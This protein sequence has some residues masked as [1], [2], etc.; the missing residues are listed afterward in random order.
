MKIYCADWLLPISSEPIQ[1]AAIAIEND[2]II[3][4]GKLDD[5]V[6]R[7]MNVPIEDFGEAVLMPGFVNTHSH[8]ELTALR[9]FLDNVE[10]DFSAWLLRVARSRDQMMSPEDLFTSALGGAI[11]AVAAGI[12]CVADIGKHAIASTKALRTI[13]LRG[14]SYQENAF[15]LDKTV[16]QERFV[17]LKDK[18]NQLR[19]FESSLLKIGITPH[20]PYTVSPKLFE[21]ITEFALEKNLPVTIHAAESQ[22]EVELMEKGNG[23]ILDVITNFGLKWHAPKTS[24]IKYLHSLR[25]LQ[26]KPLLAHCVYVDEEDLD[27]I[28]ETDTR[29]AHCPKSNAKFAHGIAPAACFLEKNIKFG[30]GSDSVSSNNTLD[31]IEEARFAALMARTKSEQIIPAEKILRLATLG[32]A[33]ALGLENKIGTLETGK[34]ADFIVISLTAFPQ[35]PV[36]DPVAAILFSSS[37]RDVK[38]TVIAGQEIYRDGQVTTVDEKTMRERLKIISRKI[39]QNS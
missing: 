21:L 39:M 13:G 32:G 37:A 10:H 12:T 19:Q 9:G 18:I 7:Y 6:A 24:S 20:A 15:A 11:E 28:A 4:V 17:E 31:L 36:Y 16:A 27:I 8:L 25:V 26:T 23:P 38:L 29:I 3:D 5:I 35:Q 2:R 14:I 33:F 34:Q 1:K 30:L 22:A